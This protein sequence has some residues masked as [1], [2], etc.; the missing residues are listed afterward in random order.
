MHI[1]EQVEKVEK[2]IRKRAC[3]DKTGNRLQDGLC[4][5]DS[6]CPSKKADEKDRRAKEMLQ[7]QWI[8]GNR[9]KKYTLSVLKHC[10]PKRNDKGIVLC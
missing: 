9:N 8:L 7:V 5:V 10:G 6:M 2:V 3:E 1:K 4:T